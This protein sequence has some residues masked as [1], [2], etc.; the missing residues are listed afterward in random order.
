MSRLS[1]NVVCLLI[2]SALCFS[3]HRPG[4]PAHKSLLF[5]PD[6]QPYMFH[7]WNVILVSVQ[8]IFINMQIDIWWNGGTWLLLG[9]AQSPLEPLVP[10]SW[11]SLLQVSDC[12]HTKYKACL[13]PTSTV[14][15]TLRWV[16]SAV[17]LW[18]ANV[19]WVLASESW[20]GKLGEM[21]WISPVVRKT[22]PVS[23]KPASKAMSWV[24]K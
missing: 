24:Q 4:H 17:N 1:H 15:W 7:V 14:L 12:E 9:A 10:N 21:G 11:T 2:S 20:K 18:R 23:P 16:S 3:R 8:S 13:S 6:S 19:C 22:F 5:F